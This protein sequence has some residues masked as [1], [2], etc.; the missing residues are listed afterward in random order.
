MAKKIQQEFEVLVQTVGEKKALSIL[1]QV[2]KATGENVVAANKQKR[3][4]EG[5]YKQELATGKQFSRQ[6]QGLGGL[7]R[8]YATVAA[9]I[10]A[11]SSAFQVLRSNANLQNMIESSNELS[12]VTGLMSTSIARDLQNITKGALDFRGALESANLAL[13]GGTTV[14]QLSTITNIATKAAQTLGRSVPDAVNRM[15]QAVTKAEPELV[16]EFGIILRV[17]EAN[18]AYAESLGKTAEQLTTFERQQALVN[19]LIE[20]GTEKFSKVKIKENPY[21]VLASSLTE[22]SQTILTFISGPISTLVSVISGSTVA[23]FGLIALAINK[24]VKLAMPELVKSFDALKERSSIVLNTLQKE[25]ARINLEKAGQL[26]GK[27][28]FDSKEAAQAFAI[29]FARELSHSFD[30]NSDIGRALKTGVAAKVSKAM[31]FDQAFLKDLQKGIKNAQGGFVKLSSSL[32][33]TSEINLEYAEDLLASLVQVYGEEVKI[34]TEATKTSTIFSRLQVQAKAFGAAMSTTAKAGLSLGFSSKGIRESFKDLDNTIKKM[35][36]TSD[37]FAN[38]FNSSLL[39]IGGSIGL[40][41]GKLLKLAST[42]ISISSGV[43]LVVIAFDLLKKPV[44]SFL[45]A[46][47]LVSKRWLEASDSLD[48]ANDRA[49]ELDK[50]FGKLIKSTK[51]NEFT[52]IKDLSEYYTKTNNIAQQ[53]LQTVLDTT[54]ALR[55]MTITGT[56]TTFLERG[57]NWLAEL[58]GGGEKGAFTNAINRVKNLSKILGKD[59][60][61][62]GLRAVNEELTKI[63]ESNSVPHMYDLARAMTQVEDKSKRLTLDEYLDK[64]DKA[65]KDA[66]DSFN[67]LTHAINESQIILAKGDEIFSGFLKD[68]SKATPFD[69]I[70]KNFK[71]LANNI[72][73]IMKESGDD[74]QRNLN[75]LAESTSDQVKS[76]LGAVGGAGSFTEAVQ[77]TAKYFE[78]VVTQIQTFNIQLETSKRRAVILNQEVKNGI[79]SSFTELAEV[80]R[81]IAQQQIDSN[82]YLIT[83]NEIMLSQLSTGDK[84]R[85]LLEA[86]LR[87]LRDQNK[88]LEKVIENNSTINALAERRVEISKT[89]AYIYSGLASIQEIRFQT[90]KELA[91]DKY[92]LQLNKL[93]NIERLKELNILKEAANINEKNAEYRQ[94]LAIWME[95]GNRL[96]KDKQGFIKESTEHLRQEVDFKKAMVEWQQAEA[97]AATKSLETNREIA[98]LL[99]ETTTFWDRNLRNVNPNFGKVLVLGFRREAEDFVANMKTGI[100][101]IVD[102]VTTGFDTASETLITNLVEGNKLFQN[103]GETIKTALRESIASALTE[104]VQGAI[105]KAYLQ[106]F[107]STESTREN[108]E[109]QIADNLKIINSTELDLIQALN[110]LREAVSG[111]TSANNTVSGNLGF[112]SSKLDLLSTSIDGLKGSVDEDIRLTSLVLNQN[113]QAISTG[114]GTIPIGPGGMPLAPPGPYYSVPRVRTEPPIP[115]GRSDDA[116]ATENLNKTMNAATDATKVVASVSGE[117]SKVTDLQKVAVIA[118]T[119]AIFADIASRTASDASGFL[120]NAASIAGIFSTTAAKGALV[121]KPTAVLAGEGPTSEAIVPLPDN[122]AIPVKFNEDSTPRQSIIVNQS[123]DFRGA[124]RQAVAELRNQSERIKKETM[125]AVFK[126]INKG[127]TAAK[128]SGRRR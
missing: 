116:K 42:L 27:G 33:G 119:A 70:A 82:T 123:F 56:N 81:N 101:N 88:E 97:L 22:L 11:V 65:A 40:I 28:A 109:K 51:D 76:I 61:I 16:D 59:I 20:Q 115:P 117:L 103:F 92:A 13:S 98:D 29:D 100:E 75:R 44:L 108:V 1:R 124:D 125:N 32:L 67:S 105:R 89:I 77:N 69:D 50:E 24:I 3:A 12:Q 99:I 43:G 113:Q 86:Q 9:N 102:I 78:K 71:D 2:N 31:A 30:P 114:S 47:N 48:K 14:T 66:V 37:T 35:I 55:D 106:K 62:S 4:S 126:E 60:E 111:N 10:F 110:L 57:G 8:V 90:A 36:G 120:S 128:I 39:R 127:G 19:Q 93:N 85:S 38:R 107:G 41:T 7:V 53:Y 18:E 21:D 121:H 84:H 17:R 94:K 68:V 54:S 26:V 72:A 5:L 58:F 49:K 122:R 15:I 63:G 80:N 91:S 104:Q 95:T 79:L 74:V 6:A 87:I 83:Q 73:T 96:E 45:K 23:S 112:T 64:V 46:T 118:N 34:N 52:S 25:L